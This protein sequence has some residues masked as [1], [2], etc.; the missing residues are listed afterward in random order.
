MAN[1]RGL[2]CA[3]EG[4][5]AD[6]AQPDATV[7]SDARRRIDQGIAHLAIAV[8]YPATLAR[9]P[10][11]NLPTKM[12]AATLKFAVLTDTGEDLWHDGGIDNIMAE[13]RRAHDII[14]RDDV[15][16]AAVDTLQIG[17]AEISSALLDNR[18]AIERLIH[19]LGVGVKGDV[20]APVRNYLQ[21]CR[22]DA[23]ECPHFSGATFQR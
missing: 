15:L 11:K 2:R 10:F 20:K 16:Q 7:L 22:A 1:V 8:V 3:L 17:L 13:L 18:G 19:L 6:A 23:G 9:V 4:K 5:I 21:A 12:S 14:V